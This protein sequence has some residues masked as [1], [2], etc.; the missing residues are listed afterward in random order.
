MTFWEIF[1]PCLFAVWIVIGI[2]TIPTGI[3]EEER[4]PWGSEKEGGELTKVG[5]ILVGVFYLFVGPFYFV[6]LARKNR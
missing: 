1:W 4:R 6:G 2:M 5:H 3:S